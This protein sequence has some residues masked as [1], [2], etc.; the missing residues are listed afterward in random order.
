MEA[1]LVHLENVCEEQEYMKNVA[2]H[3]KQLAVY[4]MKK[5]HELQ[6]YRGLLTS[7]WKICREKMTVTDLFDYFWF[8]KEHFLG[9][10]PKHQMYTYSFMS[11]SLSLFHKLQPCL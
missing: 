5:E 9:L 2:S 11:A 6:T 8:I 4:K 1:G 3:H 10:Q 7:G